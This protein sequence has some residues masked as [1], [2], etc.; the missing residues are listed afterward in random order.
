MSIDTQK[1]F[2]K[3]NSLFTKYSNTRVNRIPKNPII[4]IGLCGR[5]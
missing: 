4:N 5:S 1:D 3:I 2:E